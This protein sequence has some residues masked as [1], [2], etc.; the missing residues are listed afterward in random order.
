MELIFSIIFYVEIMTGLRRDE[1]CGLKWQDFDET[2]GILKIERSV[3]KSSEK[4]GTIIGKTKTEK[5]KRKILLPSSVVQVLRK[6]KEDAK[7]ERIFPSVTFY[8]Y[9]LS[10]GTAYRKLEEKNKIFCESERRF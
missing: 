9:A 6:R 5:S 4:C 7:S 10:P 2:N 1:I 3:S 8:K